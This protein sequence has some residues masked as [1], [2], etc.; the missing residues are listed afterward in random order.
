MK[1][2]STIAAV[3]ALQ[4]FC[5]PL[6]SEGPRRKQLRA[7]RDDGL[8]V[9]PLKQSFLKNPRLMPGTRI[10]L[11]M[12]AGWAGRGGPIET[13]LGIIAK[14]VGRSA[15]QVQRYLKDAMEEGYL[16]TSYVKDRVGR[17]TGLRIRLTRLAIF[18]EAKPRPKAAESVA[19]TSLSDNKGNK[20]LS[21]VW[22]GW[23]SRQASS[24]N[25]SAAFDADSQQRLLS[26]GRQLLGVALSAKNGGAISPQAT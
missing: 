18:H 16:R 11:S 4:P 22:E 24:R 14:H 10:V 26:K 9:K 2:L 21:N 15:R 20:Y 25:A 12:L 23:L 8:F 17:I 19:T 5:M 6:Q 7:P 1:H 3:Q 13:T